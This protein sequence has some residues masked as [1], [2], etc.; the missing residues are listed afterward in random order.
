MPA[1]TESTSLLVSELAELLVDKSWTITTAESCTGGMLA[2]AL[3]D[4][5]GSSAW[6]HQ[7]VVS[8]ANQAK[9]ELLDVDEALLQQYGAVS[10]QVVEAMA[11]GASRRAG[12]HIAVAI[13]GVAGPGGGT[14]EKPVG[15]VWIAWA[16]GPAHVE[17]AHYLFNGDRSTVREAALIEALRGTIRSVKST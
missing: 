5:A 3:T 4:I 10:K 7:G 12:A 17:A 1:I 11:A 15:T 16:L 13:S 2:A 6:F 14:V 8:Y 9:V